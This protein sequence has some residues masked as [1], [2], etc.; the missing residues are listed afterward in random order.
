[1]S[2]PATGDGLTASPASREPWPRAS[3]ARRRGTVL[4]LCLVIV[5]IIVALAAGFVDVAR[6]H[7]AT[8]DDGSKML[9]AR[10]S[11]LDGRNHA[12]EQIIRAYQSEPVTRMSGAADVAFQS[13]VRPYQLDDLDV[14]TSQ[15][16]RDDRSST[17]PNYTDTMCYWE[18][19]DF[20][21]LAYV[22]GWTASE[23]RGRYIEPEFYN[24]LPPL[25]NADGSLASTILSLIPFGTTPA[26]APSRNAPLLLDD[27][28]QRIGGDPLVGRTTARYR[29][30]YCVNVIDLDGELLM[31]PDPAIQPDRITAADPAALPMTPITLPP[32][33]LSGPD[34]RD[35]VGA[36]YPRI[37]RAADATWNMDFAWSGFGNEEPNE[38]GQGALGRNEHVFLG[39]GLSNNFDQRLPFDHTPSPQDYAPVTFPLM[40]RGLGNVSIF[41]TTNAN[42]FSPIADALL[43]S[44]PVS[45]LQEGGVPLPSGSF[46]TTPSHALVGAQYSFRNA[47]T[48]V[49]SQN[50]E[51]VYDYG[52]MCWGSFSPFGR[53]LTNRQASRYKEHPASSLDRGYSRWY[54]DV[55][56]PWS[57]NPLT[58]PASVLMGM[59]IGYAPPGAIQR[60]YTY[61]NDQRHIGGS[62]YSLVEGVRDLFI[63]QLSPAFARYLPPSRTLSSGTVISPD[64]HLPG[65]RA[66]DNGPAADG[67]GGT[68]Q[69]QG[70]RAPA[71]R[72]PG[73]LAFEGFTPVSGVLVHDDLGHYLR[74]KTNWLDPSTHARCSLKLLPPR[75]PLS[76]QQFWLERAWNGRFA[77]IPYNPQGVGGGQGLNWQ[78]HDWLLTRIDPDSMYAAMGQALCAAI[79]VARGQWLQFPAAK[80]NP[81]G[82]FAQA[83]DVA[84]TWG[85]FPG[86]PVQSV[87]DLD[88]LFLANLGIDISN[89][90][91]QQAIPVWGAPETY[92]ITSLATPAGLDWG[93]PTDPHG[94]VLMYQYT[95]DQ[96]IASLAHASFFTGNAP[97]IAN[98]NPADPT[99]V[100]N[101][102]YDPTMP[103][104]TP[105]QRAA[106]MELML[107][108]FRMSF[109]GAAPGYLG[110][111]QPLDFDGDGK[112]LCSAYPSNPLASSLELQLHL[113][114]YQPPGTPVANPFSLTGC[115]ELGK[116]HFYRILSR[117]EIWDN[118]LKA[119]ASECLLDSVLCVDPADE[120][121]ALA[122][123]SLQHAGRQYSTHLLYQRTWSDRYR[124][125]MAR[126]H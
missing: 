76:A 55:D 3:M 72:Y 16:D 49:Y 103:T 18:G 13:A 89:P 84:P 4:L 88:A 56:V 113:D 126:N 12:I 7:Q 61:A 34:N 28:W 120:A 6:M 38:S 83:P 91:S 73:P 10:E 33:M 52:L 82:L 2:R 67:H 95:P 17:D 9:L 71:D 54:G 115:F 43:T 121:N 59:L 15:L 50:V 62:Y 85:G 109:L 27:R 47:D 100:A 97:T 79:T 125:D 26:N 22:N 58:A 78:L 14:P 80:A 25:V 37:L 119:P 24:L 42:D 107:N 99:T 106:V 70:Y 98:P 65:N 101:P 112:V 90:A 64:F 66:S 36:V 63:P 74:L 111:F 118:F 41:K 102:A 23:G 105:A 30:R 93:N 19:G 123:A 75:D 87:Q 39:R 69:H 46:A 53:G 5:V 44:G 108:D 104:A 31:N 8:G 110:Q 94:Q 1:M 51:G 116:S 35:L 68:E 45:P 114:Q 20:K 96:T 117:G 57:V 122:P 60:E 11:A 124:G 92:G 86:T 21:N 81:A 29:M 32:G 48:A 40:Y 77:E